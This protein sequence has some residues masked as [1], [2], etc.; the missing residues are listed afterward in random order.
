MCGWG[1]R[2]RGLIHIPDTATN[3]I[4]STCRS[5]SQGKDTCWECLFL[6]LLPCGSRCLSVARANVK[7]SQVKEWK[8]GPMYMIALAALST[9]LTCNFFTSGSVVCFLCSRAH[10]STHHIV[11]C[12]RTVNNYIVRLTVN[13]CTWSEVKGPWGMKVWEGRE[14]RA[15]PKPSFPYLPTF[16]PWSLYLHY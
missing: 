5:M 6:T 1:R 16:I 3:G 9:S 12:R 8:T 15:E 7:K 13:I 4:I 10:T 14:R 2:S 11:Q